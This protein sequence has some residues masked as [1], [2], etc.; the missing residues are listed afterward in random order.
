MKNTLTYKLILNDS[1]ELNEPQNLTMTPKIWLCSQSSDTKTDTKPD[2]KAI[3]W[4]Y[5]S[6]Q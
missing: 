5:K 4:K 3:G 6:L 2:T 1:F